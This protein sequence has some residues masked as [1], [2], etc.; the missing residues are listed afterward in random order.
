MDRPSFLAL[1]I[2]LYAVSTA[3]SQNSTNTTSSTLIPSISPTSFHT[4]EE[5]TSSPTY[6][7]TTEPTLEPTASPVTTEEPTNAPT[8]EPTAGPTSDPTVE[9]TTSEPTV[10]PTNQPTVSP[11]TTEQPTY[12]PTSQPSAN[13]TYE[14]TTEP[15]T[16][17]PTVGPT[18]QPTY[19]PTV[20]PTAE[21]T[22]MPTDRPTYE[23]T[24]DPTV[25]PT[26]EPTEMPTD[27]P[28]YEPTAE[29]TGE[30]TV[31]PTFELIS[32]TEMMITST[33]EPTPNPTA[34][35]CDSVAYIL[36]MAF[37]IPLLVD[38]TTTAGRE[39]V[40][41]ALKQALAATIADILGDAHDE[42]CFDLPD[43]LLTI[44]A[45]TGRR[46]LLQTTYDVSAGFEYDDSLQAALFGDDSVYNPSE[47]A[48]GFGGNLVTVM[49]EQ[50]LVES[51]LSAD[52]LNFVITPEAVTEST[53]TAAATT[54]E[55]EPVCIDA[56]VSI[57]MQSCTQTYLEEELQ[58]IA[59]SGIAD[60]AGEDDE[61]SAQDVEVTV[62]SDDDDGSMDYQYDQ[63]VCVK[64]QE[65]AEALEA[66]VETAD[67]ADGIEEDIDAATN[68]TAVASGSAQIQDADTD[69]DGTVLWQPWTYGSNWLLWIV[70]GAVVCALCVILFCLCRCVKSCCDGSDRFKRAKSS[71]Y[72]IGGPLFKQIKSNDE[73]DNAFTSDL[74]SAIEMNKKG[75][76]LNHV[77]SLDLDAGAVADAFDMNFDE[78]KPIK[79]ETDDHAAAQE[80]EEEKKQDKKDNGKQK[81]GKKQEEKSKE[82]GK[83]QS[84]KDEKKPAKKNS[85]GVAKPATGSTDHETPGGPDDD[86]ENAPPPPEPPV[87][88]H[89][90]TDYDLL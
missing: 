65:A 77:E 26:G 89:Q 81:G 69:D 12:E 80:E 38:A 14:P 25:E 6:E 78:R 3:L 57:S 85:E 56:T 59:V 68:C 67:F 49:T 73:V 45:A 21:P 37:S 66:C 82:K 27:R 2:L 88:A 29:P 10:S 30:P 42:L 40:R 48:S 54:A 39:S 8:H 87:A 86:D 33:V 13:P 19:E 15:T 23:P 84:K 28:T 41:N 20:E 34:V 5:P 18:E 70:F 16:S 83:S 90:Q 31:E 52:D 24:T 50:S 75:K 61:F 4:T 7:P 58:E 32:S 1:C 53:T 71:G 35:S 51:T 17:Q 64:D 62:E 74:K 44:T 60:C 55:P 9:P 22:E 43:G 36:E 79:Q 46:R 72:T 63:V 47:F 76:L 11:V